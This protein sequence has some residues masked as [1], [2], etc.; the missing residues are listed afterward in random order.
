MTI[1]KNKPRKL[2]QKDFRQENDV[3]DAKKKNLFPINFSKQ[4]EDR[5]LFCFLFACLFL[6]ILFR[7]RDS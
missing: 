1:L 3:L 4:T 2:N 5:F 7:D 6:S